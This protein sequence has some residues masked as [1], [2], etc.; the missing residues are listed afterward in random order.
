MR[1][2]LLLT[3]FCALA[4]GDAAEIRGPREVAPGSLVVLHVDLLPG[5]AV[6]WDITEPEDWDSRE[7]QVANGSDLVFSSGCQ[8]QTITVNALVLS[9]ADG[10]ISIQ[11]TRHK[12]LVGRPPDP[13]PPPAGNPYPPP[14]QK[15]QAAVGAVRS[16]KLSRPDATNLAALYARAASAQLGTTNALRDFVGAEGRKLNLKGKYP[17]LA[18]AV[19][20]YLQATLGL[21][22]RELTPPDTESLQALAWAVWETGK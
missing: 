12:I 11:R 1:F 16:L 22:M 10:R 14:S 3:L 6:V 4:A 5:A 2:V 18:E 19:E 15:L 20:K 8:P 7:Y 17:G 9:L 21:D 13:P